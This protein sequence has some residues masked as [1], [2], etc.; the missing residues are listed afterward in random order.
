MSSKSGGRAVMKFDNGLRRKLT[1]TYTRKF[2]MKKYESKHAKA[3]KTSKL[4]SMRQRL[5]SDILFT[6]LQCGR[7]W[8]ARFARVQNVR[9]KNLSLPRRSW[10][11]CASAWPTRRGNG[12]R[13]Q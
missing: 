6:C 13:R 4:D 1:V 2:N 3:T 11:I 9:L 7:Q 10:N 8:S 12:A 5:P